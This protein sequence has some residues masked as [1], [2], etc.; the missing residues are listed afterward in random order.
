M[1]QS[2]KPLTDAMIETLRSSVGDGPR[3]EISDKM[4]KGLRLR[5]GPRSATWSM[6]LEVDGKRTRHAVG[7]WPEVGAEEARRIARMVGQPQRGRA[8]PSTVDAL[9]TDYAAVKAPTLRR[10]RSTMN[11]LK[12]AISSIRNRHP[13]TLSRRDI[14]DIVA[15]KAK[16][17]PSHA[18]R[19][20][21]YL[22]AL[23]S[24][25]VSQGL[26]DNN[27]A[28]GVGKPAREAARERTPTVDE[29]AAIWNASISRPHPYG[30]IVQMLILTACRRQEVAEMRW[31]EVRLPPDSAT[32]EWTIPAARTKTGRS[33]LI[34]LSAPA[35]EI[36]DEAK[37]YK[38]GEL[39]FATYAGVS[40]QSWSKAK[41]ALDRVINFN[42][43]NVRD[44][45]HH[46]FRR[47]FA[48]YA[49]DELNT[50]PEIV[51]RCLN[52]IGAGT[53]STVARVYARGQLLQQR[54]LAL[55]AWADAIMNAVEQQ[56]GPL[57]QARET[58]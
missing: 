52:H 56:S 37:K 39:V 22:K 8:A 45:T 55:E 58:D 35:R 49:C 30:P 18:N 14:A 46:D 25:G 38:S 19:Q 3:V 15:R 36:L 43:G 47:S 27:P 13:A 51:D 6:V 20:L 7:D 1:H 42:N 29:I 12:D 4:Q 28:Q 41:I 24:W 54:R 16:F 26:I 21:A 11:S 23:F 50:P 32:G 34:P 40:F 48:T 53:S 17:A 10:E 44:W 57:R 31:N 5:L 2:F 9:L 33:I